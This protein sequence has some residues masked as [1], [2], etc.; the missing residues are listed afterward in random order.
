MGLTSF[1]ADLLSVFLK[2]EKKFLR[3]SVKIKEKH[4]R[5]SV[6]RWVY[7]VLE[8]YFRKY[9][10]LPT[11]DVFKTELRKTSF[12][13]EK[14]K[15]YLITIKKLFKRKVKTDLK[16]IEDNVEKKV[17]QEDFLLSIDKSLI[18][19]ERGNVDTAKKGLLTDLIL[20][21]SEAEDKG[22]IIKVL[23][24][25]ETRQI[26]RYELS[27][28][29]M[30]ERFISTPYSKVNIAVKG[31][32]VSEAATVAGTTG[33]GKSIIAGEFGANSLLEGRNVLH[34]TLENTAEQTASRYDA[35]L[36]EV[37]Y[38]TIKLYEFNKKQLFHFKKVFKALCSGM[39]N[40]VIIRETIK[41]ET[42]IVLVD[43]TVEKLKLDGFIVDFLIIDSCDLMSPTRK[44]ESYRLDRASLYWDFK[45]YLKAKRLPGLTTTHLKSSSK[46][47]K[48]T[49]E[50]LA[51][52][53][54]KARILDM[55][56]II[57]QTNEQEKDRVITLSLDKNRDGVDGI[58]VDLFQDYKKMRLLEVI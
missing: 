13:S 50:G 56:F 31:I 8:K 1:E 2:D 58:E 26:A 21:S 40:D 14:K 11:I 32:Q 25:W 41:D 36:T 33:M 15:Q 22:T 44:Y 51:E 38:D 17:S 4:F 27:K 20:N 28:V 52:S 30:S 54:D 37:E 47:Q 10:A 42:D 49:V 12:D 34:F 55:V 45:F 53:Y 43:K 7:K 5:N 35:R 57:S 48:S 46:Y 29:P 3:L 23:G 16:Y 9:K 24:D 18:E 19:I 6:L 39:K